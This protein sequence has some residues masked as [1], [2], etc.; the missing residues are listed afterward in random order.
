LKTFISR[1]FQCFS[2]QTRGHPSRI[3]EAWFPIYEG[4][5]GKIDHFKGSFLLLPRHPQVRT[6]SIWKRVF[7]SPVLSHQWLRSWGR[8]LGTSGCNHL[9]RVTMINFFFACL[10]YFVCFPCDSGI[11]F[12]STRWRLVL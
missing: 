2:K 8:H 4:K 9:A 5:Q 10:S 1:S 7:L 3:L 12:S 6:S 11:R